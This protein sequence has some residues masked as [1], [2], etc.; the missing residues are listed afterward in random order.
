MRKVF[1]PRCH[2][3]CA[4]TSCSSMQPFRARHSALNSLC[5]STLPFPS[6]P[7]CFPSCTLPLIIIIFP[8]LALFRGISSLV[9]L[10]PYS[11]QRV[12]SALSRSLLSCTD[13]VCLL[14]SLSINHIS[15]LCA[16]SIFHRASRKR[17][18]GNITPPGH[19]S[20]TDSSHLIPTTR[21]QDQSRTSA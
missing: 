14:I 7:S 12:S 13:C 19:A 4:R 20:S 5:S 1:P 11:P 2:G 3:P 6:S 8:S 9:S 21:S 16:Y 15:Y 10:S 17:I 18:N